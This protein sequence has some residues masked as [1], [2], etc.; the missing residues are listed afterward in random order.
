MLGKQVWAVVFSA[1]LFVVVA[2][3]IYFRTH[4]TLLPNLF[5]TPPS[6]PEYKLGSFYAENASG[7]QEIMAIAD[8]LRKQDGVVYVKVESNDLFVVKFDHNAFNW[9]HAWRTIRYNNWARVSVSD[10]VVMD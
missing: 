3:S 2:L 8:Y 6:A 4:P 5:E 1:T 7:T 10:F 9:R